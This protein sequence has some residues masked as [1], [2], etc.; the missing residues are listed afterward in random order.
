MR[1]LFFNE[2]TSIYGGTDKVVDLEVA[3]LREK[4]IDIKLY[5]Y[6]NKLFN[7]K[8]YLSRICEFSKSFSRHLSSGFQ[9][10]IDVFNPDVIHYH[11]I[12]QMFRSPL[13]NYINS[14]GAA[15]ILHLHN[16]YPFCLNSFSY[17]KD[18]EC[19]LC[20]IKNSWLPGVKNNCYDNSKLLSILTSLNRLK[21]GSWVK[22]L[23]KISKIICVSRYLSDKFIE[24]GV[25]AEKIFLLPNAVQPKFRTP[26]GKYVLF[27]GNIVLQKGVEVLCRTA[28][29]LPNIQFVAAGEGKQFKF[30]KGKYGKLKNLTLK[31]HVSG[32]EKEE[33]LKDAR[34]LYYPS[35]CNESFGMSILEAYSYGKPVLTT[36]FGETGKLVRHKITGIINSSININSQA[37]SVSTLWNELSL[38]DNYSD[39]CFKMSEQY[40]VA[41]HI[42]KL[43]ELY[44]EILI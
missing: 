20:F 32:N 33:I 23:N 31:G 19:Q 40:S 3:G 34:F 41:N 16:F 26:V 18:K 9:Q 22:E 27:L 21:P 44:K 2:Y 14:R 17:T 10:A 4:G 37:E 1:V 7:S 28:E 35:L 5:S 12:Y 25:S 13:W 39:N 38:C 6:S 24:Y 42:H 36:G 11:N 30:I 29:L 43:L 8:N 15:T